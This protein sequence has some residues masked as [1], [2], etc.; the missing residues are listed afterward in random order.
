[1]FSMKLPPI[2]Q[3]QG[4]HHYGSC[5][6]TRGL[7]YKFDRIMDFGLFVT[8]ATQEAI[9]ENTNMLHASAPQAPHGSTAKGR[10]QRHPSSEY[11]TPCL[12]TSA[13][14]AARLLL[15]AEAPTYEIIEELSSVVTVIS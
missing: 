12:R 6:R 15:P 13:A 3:H 14:L 11:L 9:N 2:V 4:F 10:V 1:M 5:V 7:P 8:M